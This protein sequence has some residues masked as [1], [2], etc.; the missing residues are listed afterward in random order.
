MNYGI[1]ERIHLLDDGRIK[2]KIS[3]AAVKLQAVKEFRRAVMVKR[4]YAP[5]L[6]LG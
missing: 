6:V 1:L 5:L 4:Q 2:R 3:H